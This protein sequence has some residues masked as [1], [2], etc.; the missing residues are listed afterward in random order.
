[1]SPVH[2]IAVQGRSV[3]SLCWQLSLW[4]MPRAR[5]VRYYLCA[6]ISAQVKANMVVVCNS[7]IC[8]PLE[9]H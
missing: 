9:W 8:T 5:V 4:K 1:M 3:S 6:E 2:Y 7:S